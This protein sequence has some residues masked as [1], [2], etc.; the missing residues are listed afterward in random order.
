MTAQLC[1]RAWHL[2]HTEEN[3]AL[4]LLRRLMVRVEPDLKKQ[5]KIEFK[6]PAAAV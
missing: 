3:I 6:N 4:A 2:R 1:A 5:F